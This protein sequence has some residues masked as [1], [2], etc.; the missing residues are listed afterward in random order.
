MTSVAP[1][2]QTPSSRRTQ[3]TAALAP[4]WGSRHFAEICHRIN[5]TSGISEEGGGCIGGVGGP[6]LGKLASGVLEKRR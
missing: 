6:A 2:C 1:V 5:T 4:D 3:G